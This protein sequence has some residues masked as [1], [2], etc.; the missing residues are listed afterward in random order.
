MS[1]V[2]NDRTF[3]IK[4]NFDEPF[5]ATA[6]RIRWFARI[7]R[8]RSNKGRKRSNT[9]TPFNGFVFEEIFSL[10]TKWLPLH[11]VLEMT[12]GFVK[13]RGVYDATIGIREKVAGG[14]RTLLSVTNF[15]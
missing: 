5:D 8:K 15:D 13:L 11:K 1:C 14:V 12:L 4:V 9:T 10:R 2:E 7:G 3:Y 6:D